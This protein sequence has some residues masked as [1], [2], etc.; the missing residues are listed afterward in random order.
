MRVS[1]M[2]KGAGD[3]RRHEDLV[4]GQARRLDRRGDGTEDEGGSS[5]LPISPTFRFKP[6]DII[7]IPIYH[8]TIQ[9][10]GNGSANWRLL[11]LV[12]SP[13]WLRRADR[14]VRY[15]HALSKPRP[16]ISSLG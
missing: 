5:S 7:Y 9:S 13:P 8:Y 10:A 15:S 4:A 12:V 2:A 11:A 6:A 3:L 14:S 16:P 1:P